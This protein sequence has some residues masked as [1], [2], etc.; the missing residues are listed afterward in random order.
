MIGPFRLEIARFR[1]S[2][3]QSGVN[4]CE[5]GYCSTGPFSPVVECDPPAR[6]G[7]TLSPVRH[8][9][10]RISRLVSSSIVFLLFLVSNAHN[11]SRRQT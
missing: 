10:N 9:F 11:F 3:V 7:A 5:T 6:D 1:V 8:Y 4:V 2:L